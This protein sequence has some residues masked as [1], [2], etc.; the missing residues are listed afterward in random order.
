MYRDTN[1]QDLSPQ[2]MPAPGMHTGGLVGLLLL[3]Y[4]QLAPAWYAA[5]PTKSSIESPGRTFKVLLRS[6]EPVVST[7]ATT[8]SGAGNSSQPALDAENSTG[9]PTGESMPQ[10][11]P[12][13]TKRGA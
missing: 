8:A 12:E 3:L 2:N 5:L 7:T 4:L 9:P 10:L 6:S 13:V 1:V 11:L